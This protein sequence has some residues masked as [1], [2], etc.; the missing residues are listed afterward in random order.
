[1]HI[2][3]FPLHLHLYSIHTAHQSS[4]QGLW[5]PHWHMWSPLGGCYHTRCCPHSCKQ[6]KWSVKCFAQGRSGWLSGSGI[7]TTNSSVIRQDTQRTESQSAYNYPD[8][9]PVHIIIIGY[10]P[11]RFIFPSPPEGTGESGKS[12]F[13]KQMRIIHG[14]G[15]TDDDR[16]SYTKLVYQNIFTSMQSMVRATETLKIPFKYEQNKV[17]AHIV[18]HLNFGVK[19]FLN[20]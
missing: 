17:S 15:Y 1:M 20:G 5:F 19:I 10:Q 16:K 7:W 12:T 2:Q 4:L 9:R 14:S 11:W 8:D 6:L 13:I 3:Y 18:S